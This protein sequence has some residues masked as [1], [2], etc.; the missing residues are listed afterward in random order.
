MGFG[1]STYGSSNF[2]SLLPAAAV[3]EEVAPFAITK[4]EQ[5]AFDALRLTFSE[6]TISN[7]NYLNTDNYLVTKEGES[8]EAIAVK[9]VKKIN[10]FVTNKVILWTDYQKEGV[11]Y[12]IK[13]SNLVSITGQAIESDTT[14]TWKAVKT[15]TQAVIFD[16]LPQHFDKRIESKIRNVLTAVS[17]EDDLIGGNLSKQIPLEINETFTKTI[18]N[19]AD[20]ETPNIRLVAGTGIGF[21]SGQ[22][23]NSW[24]DQGSEGT[25][26][27]RFDNDTRFQIPG[28]VP[29]Y[30]SNR[31]TVRFEETTTVGAKLSSPILP[32]AIGNYN[33]FSGITLYAVAAL[34]RFAYTP[35]AMDMSAYLAFGDN[36]A[37]STLR[38]GYANS[39]NLD[40]FTNLVFRFA[41]RD[42]GGVKSV[43]SPVVV[44]DKFY[45]LEARHD[46]S[47]MYLNVNG[48]SEVSTAAGIPTSV[49]NEL[50][51]LV[52]P[53]ANRSYL[54]EMLVYD[55]LLNNQKRSDIRKNLASLWKIDSVI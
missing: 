29:L 37:T 16:N 31:S 15:K 27:T 20:L 41:I 32:N 42:A 11:T 44:P 35:T 18:S 19:A 49:T 54:G 40:D 43:N 2:G 5:I 12:E 47:T 36:P 51:M 24:A 10:D 23:I 28:A 17:L 1:S 25:A 7:A 13:V 3:A 50:A 21:S 45:V 38:F 46:G 8:V 34:H 6:E 9:Q 52:Y 33:G 39:V 48:G 4:V 53:G 26:F 55:S 14:L 22:N 30:A